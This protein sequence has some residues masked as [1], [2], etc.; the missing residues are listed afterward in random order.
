MFV[1]GGGY[2]FFGCLD[3]FGIVGCQVKDC[4]YGE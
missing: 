2:G 4:C 1:V 3:W